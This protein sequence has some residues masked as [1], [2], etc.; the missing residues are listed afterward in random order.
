MKTSPAPFCDKLKS[1]EDFMYGTLDTFMARGSNLAVHYFSNLV[2]GFLPIQAGM[3]FVVKAKRA[4][5]RA[6]GDVMLLRLPEYLL[7]PQRAAFH[8]PGLRLFGG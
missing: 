2:G 7:L 5:W 8:E 1:F 3:D 4:L 6:A